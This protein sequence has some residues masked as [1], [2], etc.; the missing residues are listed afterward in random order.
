MSSRARAFAPAAFLALAIAV[1]AFT[2]L[3]L[4]YLVS[5]AQPDMGDPLR[6]L[7]ALA[8]YFTIL[9]NLLTAVTFAAIGLGRAP[10]DRWVAAVV[11]AIGLVGVVYHLLLAPS[12]TLTGLGFWADFGLHTIVPTAAVFWWLGFGGR[13]LSLRDLPYWVIWP[14]VYCGYALVRG[15]LDG[16]YPYFF[17]DLSRHDAGFVVSYVAAISAGFLLAGLVMLAI[18]R[19]LHRPQEA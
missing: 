7:W 3:G 13:K 10:A 15:G 14:L 8:R 11:L 12:V 17:L 16:R 6:T 5:N 2:S 18:A 1:S 19:L 9:T 4:Q